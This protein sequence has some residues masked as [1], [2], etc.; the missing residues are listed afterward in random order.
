MTP[1]ITISHIAMT[2]SSFLILAASF[3]RYCITCWLSK[4]KKVNKYRRWI[5]AGAI[6]IGFLT[7]STLAGEFEVL[8]KI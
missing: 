6:F 8:L 7:K 1:L 4:V 2:S 5:A 3:E